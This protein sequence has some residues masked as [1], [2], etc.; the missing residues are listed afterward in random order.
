MIRTSFRIAREVSRE[1]GPFTLHLGGITSKVTLTYT[2]TRK[3]AP[4]GRAVGAGANVVVEHAPIVQSKRPDG[5]YADAS[6][7]AEAIENALRVANRVVHLLAFAGGSR[8]NLPSLSQFDLE[9][10]ACVDFREDPPRSVALGNLLTETRIRLRE[11]PVTEQANVQKRLDPASLTFSESESLWHDGVQGFYNARLREAVVL[12]R[13]SIEVAWN[14]AVKAA[15]DAYRTCPLGPVPV[16]LIDGF[17]DRATD[18][19]MA[20]PD[21]LDTS[22][23]TIFDFSFKSDWESGQTTKWDKL[24]TFFKQRHDVAHGTGQPTAEHAWD[25]LALTREVLDRLEQLTDDVVRKCGS[26]MPAASSSG[27]GP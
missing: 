24:N 21:R 18:W 7:A 6:V 9:N 27:S 5:S 14:A 3:D 26:A 10:L 11:P 4:P 12:L 15:G 16:G 19:R 2:E 13:A 1:H 8:A 17:I 23:K 25:A 20:L 22:S